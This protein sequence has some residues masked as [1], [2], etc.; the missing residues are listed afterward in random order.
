MYPAVEMDFSFEFALFLKQHGTH[1]FG[2]HELDG[3]SIFIQYID[4]VLC[5]KVVVA[6]VPKVKVGVQ[7]RPS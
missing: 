3:D 4:P 6:A 7:I 5:G 1:V 2:L